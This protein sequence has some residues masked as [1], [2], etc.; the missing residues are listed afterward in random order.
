M[1]AFLARHYDAP[2]E[3]ERRDDEPAVFVWR[4]RRHVVREVLAHWWQTGA[5]WERLDAGLDDDEREIWRVEAVAAGHREA[6]RHDDARGG[7]V[8][9]GGVEPGGALRVA[10][11]ELDV[12][13]GHGEI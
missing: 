12:L 7:G 9:G 10:R 6:V 13:A 3:V 4:G 11:R 1:P 5:W 2:T 8:R